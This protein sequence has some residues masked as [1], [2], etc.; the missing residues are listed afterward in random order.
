[1]FIEMRFKHELACWR[2]TDYSPQ[3]QPVV[4]TP[5]H[6]A[7]PSGH[8]TQSYLVA[9][10][11]GA[12]LA[13]DDAEP[14]QRAVRTQLQRIAAR[15][16]TNRVIAGVHFPVDNVA[17]RLLGT[18]LADY[19]VTRCGA[20]TGGTG[21]RLMRGRFDG[22]LFPPAG[23]FDPLRQPLAVGATTDP[24]YT[25][26]EVTLDGGPRNAGLRLPDLAPPS[27]L[28]ELWKEAQRE[29]RQ[30]ALPSGVRR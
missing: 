24:Y 27:I 25:F 6:G 10:V 9:E 8:C 13:L 7:L 2:P 5:G 4:T 23:E 15:I 11:L 14:A 20:R 26:E 30:L 17:G 21:R 3:V 16:S 22:R 19:F 1:V 29:L 28:T 12:L 18:V